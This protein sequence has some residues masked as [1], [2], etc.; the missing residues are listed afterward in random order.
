MCPSAAVRRKTS[1][2]LRV[3]THTDIHRWTLWHSTDIIGMRNHLYRLI[4]SC[5]ILSA[6]K[7]I[8]TSYNQSFVFS[9]FSPLN[10]IGCSW[11]DPKRTFIAYVRDNLSS[12]NKQLSHRRVGVEA[13]RTERLRCHGETFAI[14]AEKG[15]WNTGQQHIHQPMMMT[16][17]VTSVNCGEGQ[18]THQDSQPCDCTPEVFVRSGRGRVSITVHLLI[19]P[20]NPKSWRRD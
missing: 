13:S 4:R 14:R 7:L 20:S 15:T 16:M 8:S 17:S 3:P 9:F 1:F 5:T 19:T 2:S 10:S 12:N 11:N 18:R 6:Q